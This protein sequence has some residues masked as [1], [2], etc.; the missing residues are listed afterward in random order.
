[1]TQS[2]QS[3]LLNGFGVLFVILNSFGLK[4]HRTASVVIHGTPSSRT[5]AAATTSSHRI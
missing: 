4:T 1:M 5:C 2:T 3:V